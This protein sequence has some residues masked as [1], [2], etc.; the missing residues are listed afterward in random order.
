MDVRHMLLATLLVCLCFLTAHSHLV[1]EEKPRDD[2]SLRNNSSINLLYFPSVSIVALN[3]KSKII[4]RKEAEKMKRSSKQKDS[5]KKAGRPPPPLS[6]S[7]VAT[8]NSCKPPAPACCHPCVSCQC[9]FFRSACS[10][11]VLNPN[12]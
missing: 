12:C 7:C 11:R 3:K 6:A 5:V 10:C 2:R 1:L 8:R 9:R 4:S